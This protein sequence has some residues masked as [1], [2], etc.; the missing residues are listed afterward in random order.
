LLAVCQSVI[1]LASELTVRRS[2][3]FEDYTEAVRNLAAL[4]EFPE[5][6]V[7]DLVPL[8]GFRNVLIHEYVALDMA[9]VVEALDHLQP[10]EEFAEI[11]RR[12]EAGEPLT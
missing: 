7:R 5:A 12:L 10:I 3:R 6:L 4:P 9:R 2:L 1:D 11:V 8:P